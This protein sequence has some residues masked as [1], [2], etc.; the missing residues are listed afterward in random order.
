MAIKKIKT[1][2]HGMERYLGVTRK[3]HGIIIP[4]KVAVDQR[5]SAGH[6]THGDD[7]LRP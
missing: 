3:K 1:S 4:S 5:Q 2:N 7:Q 6:K